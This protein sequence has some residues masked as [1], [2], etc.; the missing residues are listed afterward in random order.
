MGRMRLDV[1]LLRASFLRRLDGGGGGGGRKFSG[2]G[3]RAPGVAYA[4]VTF[5][6]GREKIRR[7]RPIVAAFRVRIAFF[8]GRNRRLGNAIIAVAV[9]AVRTRQ[10]PRIHLSVRTTRARVTA[11]RVSMGGRRF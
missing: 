9:V 2:N 3:S 8:R 4:G 6:W 7:F 1:Y 5:G 10:S 11:Y